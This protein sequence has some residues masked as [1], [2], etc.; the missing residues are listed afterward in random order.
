MSLRG[1]IVRS[2]EADATLLSPS[3]T[4][5]TRQS[6]DV[7]KEM[8]DGLTNAKVYLLIAYAFRGQSLSG[9]S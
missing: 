5:P 7:S 2:V 9:H 4:P 8:P 3:N 1:V 6:D